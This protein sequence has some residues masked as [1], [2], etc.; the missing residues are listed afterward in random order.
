MRFLGYLSDLRAALDHSPVVF[1]WWWV[2]YWYGVLE[3]CSILLG[4]FAAA[5]VE[6]ARQSDLAPRLRSDAARLAAAAPREWR[7]FLNAEP[8]RDWRKFLAAAV[9]FALLADLVLAPKNP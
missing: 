5:A 7:A 1:L 6:A 2:E 4:R 3:S 9:G 8:V